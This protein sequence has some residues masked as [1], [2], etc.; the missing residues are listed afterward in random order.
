[1]SDGNSLNEKY[2]VDESA[3][4]SMG[5]NI[6][7]TQKILSAFPALKSRNYFLY[8]IGQLLSLIGTWL[9]IVAEGW[10]VFQLSHSAFYVG[11]D[12]AIATIP[13][14]F[15]SLYGGVIVDR[16]P[17]RKILI[18]T[19]TASMILAFILGLL[20]VFKIIQVWQI[21]FLAFLLGVVNAID[22]PARQ[23]YV[24]ELVDDKKYLSSA[25]ALNSGMFNAAR[26][27]GPTV[28]G[29]LIA[30]FGAGI[31]F[32]LNGISYIAVIIALFYINTTDKIIYSNIH[33]I[34]A[35]REGLKYAFSSSTIKI[36]LIL[37]AVLSIFGWSYGTLMPVMANNVYHINASG[38][39]YLYACAGAGAL[40][41]A[42][43]ISAFS[44]KFNHWSIIIFGNLFFAISLLIFTFITNVYIAAFFLFFIGLGI[45]SQFSMI[46][47]IIQNSIDDHMRGRVM[48]IYTISFIGLAPIGNFEI[49][50]VAEKL[51]TELAIRA[52][53]FILVA[54]GILLL[55][56][57]KKLKSKV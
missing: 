7:W 46:N 52:N 54:F 12:A 1:M 23:A 50:L 18:F 21:I 47:T 45:V 28:A 33:P 26:V 32:L 53:A 34:E 15:L 35:I 14:L 31:A 48:A 4:I 29:L 44:H 41:G 5:E 16:F 42:F 8:F 30:G 9:Q 22:S 56:Y 57:R 19:Q 55:F 37:S 40:L 10:L 24:V 6:G 13:T 38:L 17:K 43:L 20:A 49:G 27:I 36:L 51:G 39:G 25:I 2:I 3:E 11:L